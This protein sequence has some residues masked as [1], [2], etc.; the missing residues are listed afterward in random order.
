METLFQLGLAVLVT[1]AV[2]FVVGIIQ[3]IVTKGKSKVALRIVLGSAITFFIV[4]AIGF[5]TCVFAISNHWILFLISFIEALVF[6]VSFITI[7]VG[8]FKVLFQKE[9]KAFGVKLL[10]YAIIAFIIGFGTCAVAI[11]GGI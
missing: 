2:L 3:L 8:L 4:I 10:I 5:G 6:V 7:L 9:D 11:N 1:C